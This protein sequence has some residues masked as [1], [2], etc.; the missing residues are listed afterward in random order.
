[1]SKITKGLG[2]KFLSSTSGTKAAGILGTG[3]TEASTEM[4]QGAATKYNDVLGETGGLGKDN[5]LLAGKAADAFFDHL[6]SQE[7]LEEG[8]QGFFGGSGIKGTGVASKKLLKAVNNLRAPVDS[9]AIEADIDEL[10]VL[11]QDLKKARSQVTRQG[12]EENIKNVKQR[13]NNRIVKGNSIIPKL[14]NTEIDEVNNIGDLAELQI[15][16]TNTLNKEYAEGVIPRKEYLAALDGFKSTYIEAKNRIQGIAEEAENRDAAPEVAPVKEKVELTKVKLEKKLEEDLQSLSR[17][18]NENIISE[19][20]YNA[21]FERLTSEYNTETNK[22]ANTAVDLKNNIEGIKET[23]VKASQDLQQAFDEGVAEGTI[24]KDKD[25]KNVLTDKPFK[26][27]L[28][29]QMPFIK[30]TIKSSL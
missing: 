7:G 28:K 1:M 8:I 9:A 20:Q 11:Q 27:I 30:K 4:Y 16:R 2:P 13:L 26:A 14:T 23:S 22:I 12:I 19:Q 6:S 10:S 15:K 3:L 5:S 21:D 29:T 18:F 17:D 24:T 25:G